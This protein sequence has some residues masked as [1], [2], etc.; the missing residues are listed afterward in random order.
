M[1]SEEH[2]SLSLIFPSSH[3]Y[4]GER[5]LSPQIGIIIEVEL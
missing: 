1:Q 2:P 3:C 4:E 5:I